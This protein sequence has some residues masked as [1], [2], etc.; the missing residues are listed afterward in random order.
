MKRIEVKLS[1]TV[2]APLL[3][4]IKSVSKGLGQTLAAP[5]AMT[6]LDAEFHDDWKAELQAGQKSDVDVLLG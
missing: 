5:L 1:L 3:D 2:V 4:V 6:D